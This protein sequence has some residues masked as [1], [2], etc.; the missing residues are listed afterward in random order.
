MAKKDK[1]RKGKHGGKDEAPRPAAAT[2][3]WA[4]AFEVRVFHRPNTAQDGDIPFRVEVF[5]GDARASFRFDGE[6]DVM[7]FVQERVERWRS[8]VFHDRHHRTL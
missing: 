2:G 4:L 6:S 1:K 5:D 7:G 3:E 8:D